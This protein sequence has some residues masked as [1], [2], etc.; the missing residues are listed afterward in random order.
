[1]IKEEEPP[2]PS[3]RL[4][5]SGDTLA[6]ISAQRHME[7]AK[8]TKL[9]RGELDWIVMKALEKDRN[10]RFETA[11]A[12]AADVHRYL[13]DEPVL[14]CPPSVG[15]RVRK[16]VRRNK[17]PVLA[18]SVIALLLAAG[19][20]G[21]TTG[22][23]LALAAEGRA[24]TERDE[25]EEARRQTLQALNTT[26]DEV[27]ED[28]LG[29]QGV[30][31][32]DN[33]RDFL[34]KVL[35]YHAALAP[36]KADDAEG[37][38][39]RAQGYF[40][41]G[42]IGHRLGDHKN[43]EAAYGDAITLQKQLVADFPMRP[44][45]QQD[46]ANSQ[47]RLGEVLTATK[48]PEEA[49]A[50][51]RAA[52]P[53]WQQLAADFPRRPEFRQE[54]AQS[55]LHLGHQLRKTG[56]LEEAETAYRNALKLQDHLVADFGPRP[57]FRSDLAVSYILLG[58]LL[59]AAHRRKEADEAAHAGLDLFRQLLAEDGPSIKAKLRHHLIISLGEDPTILEYP[60]APPGAGVRGPDAPDKLPE[61]ERQSWQKLWNDAADMLQR[62]A[63]MTAADK[64]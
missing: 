26:T 36:A 59:F 44:E 54:L 45:F 12:F 61:A 57:E 4:S 9:V 49:K 48:Q 29:Q 19:I 42:R 7:P 25:K 16:F 40:R 37:R 30:E 8:L 34:K 33:R 53:L 51:Y 10:R 46:L 35:A 58:H 20:V 2:K 11:S 3:T 64:K 32:T 63:E 62:A 15:Y 22:L 55:H 14:A 56:R 47:V 31:L 6:S 43:A 18:A 1:M 38:Q 5:D 23:V 39:S 52:L 60:H 17:G 13:Y 41:V 27:V 50:A 28:L 24:V 21:T